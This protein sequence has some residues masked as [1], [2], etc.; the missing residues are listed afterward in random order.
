MYLKRYLVSGLITVIPMWVTWVVFNFVF[1]QLSKLGTP[2]VWT[3]S[4]N[5]Q[6]DSPALACWI[7]APWLPDVL[8][9]LLTRIGLYLLGWAQPLPERTGII[10]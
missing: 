10:Q 6:E 1:S 3:L 5:I 7:L 4:R 8:A 2:W 9:A